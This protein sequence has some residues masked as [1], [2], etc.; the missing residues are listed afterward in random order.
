MDGRGGSVDPPGARALA[1]APAATIKREASGRGVVP[2]QRKILLSDSE[3]TQ[4]ERGAQTQ[5]R[6]KVRSRERSNCGTFVGSCDLRPHRKREKGRILTA[7]FTAATTTATTRNPF[8]T[9]KRAKKLKKKREIK[10]GKKQRKNPAF[11]TCK[12]ALLLS[13]PPPL[14]LPPPFSLSMRHYTHAHTRN[15]SR[16]FLLLALPSARAWPEGFPPPAVTSFRGSDGFG[17]AHHFFSPRWLR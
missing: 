1:H 9:P 5:K 7:P 17:D 14:P 13:L 15:C 10:E 4:R 12:L 8:R 11:P 3:R 6:E 16:D 2:P